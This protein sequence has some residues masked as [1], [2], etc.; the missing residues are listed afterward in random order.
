MRRA[1]KILG[2]DSSRSSLDS[3][4]GSGPSVSDAASVPAHVIWQSPGTSYN[5][6]LRIWGIVTDGW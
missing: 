4:R 2:S 1:C 5:M 6:H 3:D